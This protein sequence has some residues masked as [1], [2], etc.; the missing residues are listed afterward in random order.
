LKDEVLAS[1]LPDLDVF[2][3]RLPE[4]F[5]SQLRE[6]FGDRIGAHPLRREII[7]TML[8]NEVVDGGGVSY[9]FRLAEEMTA[10]ATDAVRAYVAATRIF[11]L[12]ALWADI[13]ALDNV[14]ASSVAD[15]MTLESRRLLDRASRW[16]L[17]N[18]PQ[19]LAVGA[20]LARFSDP[21]RSLGADMLS[22]LR[23]RE[24]EHVVDET[25]RLVGIGV[26]ETTAAGVASLLDRFCLLDVIEIAELAER[27]GVTVGVERS[28]L[29][30]A[31]L[32]YA[33]SE[34]LDMDRMLSS[35]SELERGNRWHSLARL[36]LRDD[37][38][39]SI[40][41]IAVD[42]LRHS[43]PGDTA[44]DK[45]ARWEQSNASRL[46]RARSALAEIR[47]ANRL[48]LPTLSVA[49]RQVR[50]MVR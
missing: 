43:D 20:E 34:H 19:P 5:P 10:S 31:Q 26:P 48:D 32:Y 11:D 2:A 23:G 45:I 30:A 38:Y 50:S 41:A 35:V 22:L 49:A 6:R 27:E 39:S 47:R 15:A 42:V 9:A 33:L 8:V 36:A 14:V 17:T 25:A 29:E 7:T 46:A 44:D 24:R 3:R 16:L 12:P 13:R 1:D 40:R 28:H 18:R 21:V 4:Y 37:L